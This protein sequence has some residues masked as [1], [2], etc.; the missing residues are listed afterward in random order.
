MDERIIDGLY[1]AAVL[2][3]MWPPVLAQIAAAAGG[4][5]ALLSV[6]SP[7]GRGRWL[8]SSPDFDDIVRAHI[9]YFP[10][11]ERTRRLL[12]TPH[13]GFVIDSD[14]LSEAEMTAEPIYRDYLWPRGF[15]FGVATAIHAPT[16][17]ATVLHAEGRRAD[18]PI[19]RTA[20]NRLDALRP[21]LA[22]A[23]LIANRLD[24]ERARNVAAVLEQVGLPAAVLGRGGRMLAANPPLVEMMPTVLQDR[25]SRLTLA[26]PTADALFTAAL[27]MLEKAPY[28][29]AV[30]SIPIPARDEKPPVIV[31]VIPIRGAAHDIFS[32]SI[33][34]LV[35]TPVVR[36][37]GPSADVVQGLFDLTPAEARLAALIAAGHQPKAAAGMLGVTEGTARTTLKS[38]F[39]KTGLNRQADLIGL[40]QGCR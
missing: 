31:H 18:G 15:G 21:H 32:R 39:A 30:H 22:R 12:A 23:A 36:G 6:V 11:N 28:A 27:T 1:E 13:A 7:T 10:S 14:V 17:D 20:V 25:P 4:V 19:S 33:A 40:L 5:E 26:R 24:V 9:E 16:G 2:P 29:A 34:I 3:E 8:T 38:V 35:A 37:A